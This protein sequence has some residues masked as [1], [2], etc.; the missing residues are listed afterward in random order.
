MVTGWSYL[1]ASNG[2]PASCISC[3][4]TFPR[5]VTRSEMCVSL[6]SDH[7]GISGTVTEPSHSPA[8]LFM[9]VKDFCASDGTGATEDFCVS[10]WARVTVQSDSRTTDSIKRWD[11]MFILLVT[12]YFLCFSARGIRWRTQLRAISSNGPP[13]VTYCYS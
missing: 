3:T 7:S 10:D 6:P 2:V 8:R 11:F 9:V 5:E 12:S 4:R 13:R 1:V